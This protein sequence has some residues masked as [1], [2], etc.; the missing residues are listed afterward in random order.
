MSHYTLHLTDGRTADV[1]EGTIRRKSLSLWPFRSKTAAGPVSDKKRA[2]VIHVGDQVYL[3][4]RDMDGAW[5]FE[6]MGNFQPSPD[7]AVCRELRQLIE[8]HA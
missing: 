7:S 3:M 4:L 6:G 5:R 8:N 1:R 2:Y